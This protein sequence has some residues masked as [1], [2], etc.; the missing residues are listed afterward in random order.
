MRCVSRRRS[1]PYCL[2]GLIACLT[3]SGAC[4][5]TTSGPSLDPLPVPLPEPAPTQGPLARLGTRVYT[6]ADLDDEAR[7]R[8]KQVD[9]ELVSQLKR[10]ESDYRLARYAAVESEAQRLINDRILTAEAAKKHVSKEALLASIPYT[11]VTDAEVRRV[12]D[13]HAREINQPYEAVAEDLKAQL[14]RHQQELGRKA[15]F[16]GLMPTYQARVLVEPVR[17]DVV[18]NGPATGPANAPITILLYSD[19]QCPYCARV[20][21]TLNELLARHPG[22]VRLVYR[23]FPLGSIHP[24]ALGAAEAAVCADRQGRFWDVYQAFF[25]EPSKLGKSD[26]LATATRLN[27]NLES[28]RQCVDNGEG[29]AVVSAD[30]ATADGLG[31]SGTPALFINGRQVTGAPTLE[32]LEALIGDEKGLLAERGR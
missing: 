3:L 10:I 20:V 32:R 25:A 4:A 14:D 5:Q 12:Y 22:D 7:A 2:A 23:H 26:I 11:H 1:L 21:P 15:Y 17:S 8:L 18:A 9:Q 27:L 6:S 19:F 30:L 29:S 13:G 28:F 31:L 24:N 16:E